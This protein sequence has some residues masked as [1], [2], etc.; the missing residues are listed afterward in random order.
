MEYDV[1]GECIWE[2]LIQD[3]RPISYLSKGIKK[4]DEKEIFA[5]IITEQKQ[6][7]YISGYYI[8]IKTNQQSP[9]YLLKQK[10]GAS[11]YQKQI[12]KLIGYDF[13][14][15]Y[16]FVNENLVINALSIK[17]KELIIGES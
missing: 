6:R 16:K 8:Q 15:E 17:L 2:I 3:G 12:L 14:V 10:I 4:K 9:K 11:I 1:Y 13:I 5:I 7:P